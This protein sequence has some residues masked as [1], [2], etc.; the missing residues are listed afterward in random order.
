MNRMGSLAEPFFFM[1][2]FEMESPIVL[3]ISELDKNNIWI[4]T[5][6]FSN[7]NTQKNILENKNFVFEAKP[8]SFQEYQNTFEIIK[9]GI[10]HGDSFLTNLC[11]KTPINCNLSLKE[12][13]NRSKA[14][15][16]LFYNNS[17][18]VFSPER[19]VKIV[20]GDIFSYPM[21]GTIDAA[22]PDAENRIIND[23]KEKAEHNTIVDLIRND[24]GQVSESIEVSKFRYI[25]KLQTNKGDILQVSS[26][27]KG[28]LK[29]DY[30]SRLGEIIVSLLPAGSIS[31]AP[32][33]KTIEMIQQAETSK[34]GYFTGVFGV[35]DGK[36]LDSAVMIR[37]I[38]NTPKG[39]VFKSGGGITIN[40]EC[41]T[42][43]EEMIQK[44]YVPII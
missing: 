25:D 18:V 40:S 10:E 11:F 33:P 19:F 3:P 31:G 5:P 21:K 38:E 22:I 16:R 9:K 34:R 27:I 17:F 13:F 20:D 30:L 6:L 39:L 36:E 12:I 43:Y 37:F 32:K 2:D 44:V 23:R 42:E 29:G 15:F 41:Q 1:I 24:L 4:N 8:I 26:E 14:K 35:F 28:E 7:V